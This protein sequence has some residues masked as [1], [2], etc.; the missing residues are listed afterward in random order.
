[1]RLVYCALIQPSLE[2]GSTS[3]GSAANTCLE[4]LLN[5]QKLI[6]AS[7]EFVFKEFDVFTCFTQK[8]SDYT[9]ITMSI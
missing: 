3:W 4:P 6:L 1:M 5:I 9:K 7:A 8:I 2:Y